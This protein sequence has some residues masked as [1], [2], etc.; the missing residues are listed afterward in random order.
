MGI[1][2]IISTVLLLVSELVDYLLLVTY[3]TARQAMSK[4]IWETELLVVSNNT[5]TSSSSCSSSSRRLRLPKTEFV[6]KWF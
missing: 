1:I 6:D 3:R 4:S 5:T 2:A